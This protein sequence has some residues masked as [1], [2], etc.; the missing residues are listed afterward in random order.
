MDRAGPAP[1]REIEDSLCKVG[2]EE[3]CKRLFVLVRERIAKQKTV[4]LLIHDRGIVGQGDQTGT[5]AVLS[6]LTTEEDLCERNVRW[7][8]DEVRPTLVEGLQLGLG[9]LGHAH[10]VVEDKGHLLRQPSADDGV[11]SVELQ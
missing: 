7:R 1:D 3:C 6:L 2:A 11:V 10:R 5:G 9:W 4:S 8:V